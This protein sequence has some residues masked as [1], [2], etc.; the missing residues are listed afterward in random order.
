MKRV[1]AEKKSE[2]HAHVGPL[3]AKGGV[4][5]TTA[6]LL[7]CLADAARVFE[8]FPLAPG[9]AAAAISCALVLAL[10]EHNDSDLLVPFV[11]G[12]LD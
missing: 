12:F 1:W 4:R 5:C 6:R 3:H 7:L 10:V 9:G 11:A 2:Q 8:I